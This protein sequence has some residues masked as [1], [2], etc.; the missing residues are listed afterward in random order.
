MAGKR[1]EGGPTDDPTI[2]LPASLPRA[3]SLNPQVKDGP[4]AEWSSRFHAMCVNQS[5]IARRLLAQ[6]GCGSTDL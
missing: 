3:A 5:G 4:P 2:S 6:K 1:M